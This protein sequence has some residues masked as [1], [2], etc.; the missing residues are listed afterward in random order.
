MSE[1]RWVCRASSIQAIFHTFPAIIQTLE[2]VIKQGGTR[3]VDGRGLFLQILDFN[4]IL[5][6]LSMKEIFNTTLA[7]SNMLQSKG[8]DLAKACHLVDTTIEQ[9]VLL[10]CDDMFD[11]ILA[12]AVEFAETHIDVY[13]ESRPKRQRRMP[14]GLQDSIVYECACVGNTGVR[15]KSELRQEYN[16]AI[17]IIVQET[18]QR[19]NRRNQSIMRAIQ[20]LIPGS[21]MFFV[22]DAIQPLAT[23]YSVNME[24]LKVELPLAS[25]V[26]LLKY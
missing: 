13:I 9:L 22:A 11:T 10:K 17:D 26:E 23:Q 4:F 1:T 8:L 14:E 20:A 15:G 16:E 25:K 7:L 12:N 24:K 2:W 5:Q 3:A 6:L 18:R 19:F 21:D